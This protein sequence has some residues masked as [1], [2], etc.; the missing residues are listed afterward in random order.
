M[1]ELFDFIE[2][3]T[4]GNTIGMGDPVITNTG[5]S[6]PLPTTP[7]AKTK[8]QKTS[9]KHKKHCEEE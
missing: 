1:Q 8:K 3:A 9:K 5:G 7:T 2:N 6:E 4:P